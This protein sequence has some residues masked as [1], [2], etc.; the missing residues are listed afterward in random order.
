VLTGTKPD[1]DGEASFT[2]NSGSRFITPRTPPEGIFAA[3]VKVALG[4][5]LCEP[6][7]HLSYRKRLS[8]H[9]RRQRRRRRR[10]CLSPSWYFPLPFLLSLSLS[11]VGKRGEEKERWSR[12]KGRFRGRTTALPRKRM[13]VGGIVQY[14]YCAVLHPLSLLR[15]IRT[16]H[17][18]LYREPQLVLC[19]RPL[20]LHFHDGSAGDRRELYRR[21]VLGV[22]RRKRKR[23]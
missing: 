9:P 17:S 19:V 18:V 13:V 6:S 22:L 10:A 15:E 3:G 1:N 5:N 14:K 8:S 21:L 12:R 23:S 2:E 20:N 4:T 7:T 11:R 16:H